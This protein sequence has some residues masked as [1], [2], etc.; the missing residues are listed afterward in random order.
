MKAMSQ[1]LNLGKGVMDNGY[2]RFR[3]MLEYKLRLKGKVLVTIDRFYPSSK[4]CS[5][6]GNVK[7]E[8]S[9]AERMY[10]CACGNEMDRDVNAAI[11]IREEGKRILYA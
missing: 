9:L 6:C 4:R 2:G 5:V 1:C 7:E 10:R 3:N 11:N 8:L